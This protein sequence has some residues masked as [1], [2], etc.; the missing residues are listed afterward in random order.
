MAKEFDP[1]FP[2]VGRVGKIKAV[3]IVTEVRV[4]QS[5]ASAVASHE[6]GRPRH[7]NAPTHGAVVVQLLRVMASPSVSHATSKAAYSLRI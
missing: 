1:A 3:V 4:Q 7:S 2:L 6:S 5:C